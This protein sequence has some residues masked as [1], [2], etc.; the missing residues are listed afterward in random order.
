MEENIKDK[1][2]NPDVFADRRKAIETLYTNDLGVKTYIRQG[3]GSVSNT[4][5]EATLNR[6]LSNVGL[7]TI[8]TGPAALNDLLK[9]TNYAYATDANYANIVNYFANM[10]L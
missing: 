2:K 10:F 5:T 9:L 7:N 8:T 1:N 3:T 6:I 4:F